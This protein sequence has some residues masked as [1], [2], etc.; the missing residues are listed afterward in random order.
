M[1]SY[2]CLGDHKMGTR[3]TLPIYSYQHCSSRA[4]DC[5]QVVCANGITPP[6]IESEPLTGCT[7]YRGRGWGNSLDRSGFSMRLR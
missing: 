4:R 2:T 1:D 6:G 7:S 3:K 5:P